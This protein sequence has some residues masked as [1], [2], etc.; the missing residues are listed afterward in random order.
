MRYVLEANTH[1]VRQFPSRAVVVERVFVTAGSRQYST[2]D[3]DIMPAHF[4][5]S[6]SNLGSVLDKLM[7]KPQKRPLSILK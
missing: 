4:R 5:G 3:C 7:Q 1:N 6:F 2:V